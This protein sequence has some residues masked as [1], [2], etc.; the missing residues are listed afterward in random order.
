MLTETNIEPPVSEIPV[1]DT[2]ILRRFGRNVS[3]NLAGTLLSVLLALAQMALLT[4]SLSLSDYGLVLIVTNLFLFL[5]TFVGINVGDVL[6][7]FFQPFKAQPSTGA[8]QGL[9]LLCLTLCL[10]AGLLISIGTFLLSP[11]IA[12]H[13]YHNLSLAPLLQIY[14]GTVLISAFSGFYDPVLRIHDRFLSLM[15]PRV[16]GRGLAVTILAIYLARAGKLT[17]QVV[18]VVLVIGL[19]FQTVPPLVHAI[20]L[21]RPYL[22]NAG[23]SSCARA[24]TPYRSELLG[25]IW[26]VNL[27][28]YL[29]M[30]F[31]PGDVFLLGLFSSPTQVALYGLA[32]QLTSPFLIL[33]NNT[34]TAL[35]PEITSLVRDLPRMKR[36]VF[37]YAV[38]AFF[39]SSAM[40]VAAFLL[41]PSLISWLSRP[42]YLAALPVFKVLL[43]IAWLTLISLVFYPVGLSLDRLK[44][45][46]LAQVLNIVILVVFLIAGRLDALTMAYLQLIGAAVVSLIFCLPVGIRLH[47]LAR[48]SRRPD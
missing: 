35:T 13:F 2:V 29:K 1:N 19:L 6:F 20:Q 34:Q 40:V 18:V 24:L 26:H 4:K 9:L 7:R 43:V 30:V 17:L 15:I 10:A 31:S 37:R 48:P 3:I 33:Q 28:S 36:L 32:R 39:L 5:E 23:F 42:E 44:W 16:L 47:V 12:D 27:A 8:L 11:W 41:G 38:W 45:Y 21:V 22:A 14:A 46:N 25:T